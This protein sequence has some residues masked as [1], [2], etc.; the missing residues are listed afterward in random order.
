MK[1]CF[2]HINIYVFKVSLFLVLFF[3][4]KVISQNFTLIGDKA[5][6]TLGGEQ[7]PIILK[8]NNNLIIAGTTSFTGINGD[9]TEVSC[10]T[11]PFETDVWILMIDVNS[12][13]LW[14]KTIGGLNT[15]KLYG[16]ELGS[17]KNIVFT[18]VTNSDSSCDI[19]TL[20]RGSS[21]FWLCS[22]DSNGNKI[23]DNRYGS[24]SAEFGGRLL[25]CENKDYLLL[26]ASSGGI[27][28]DKTTV[29]LGGRDFWLVRTDSLGNKLWDKTLGGSGDETFATQ[30]DCS[31]LSIGNNEYLI[32]GRTN[33]FQSGTISTNGFG[34]LDLWFAKVDSVGS[35]VWDKRF[36]GNLG[37]NVT[38][39]IEVNDGYLL[40]GASNSKLGGTILDTGIIGY[41]VWLVKID[42]I[43]NQLWEK[44]YGGV[45]NDLG[46]DIQSAPDGGYWVL[47]QT[48]SQIGYDITE[49]SY[50]GNDYW[51]FKIDSVGNKSWDKRFGGPGNDFASSFIIM[52]DS[53]IFICGHAEAG[54]SAVK[55]DSGKGSED[56]WIVHFNYYN[57][58]TGI[59]ST[60]TVNGITVSPNPTQNILNVKGL[61]MGEYEAIL[62]GIDGRVIKQ[63]LLQGGDEVRYSLDDAS[64]GM[65]LLRFNG[66][67]FTA[68]I[69]VMKE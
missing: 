45:S 34:Q 41:D 24:N 10:A 2:I 31:F 22:L 55:T 38:K 53:S 42:T 46:I 65:Y 50:G 8:Y 17:D 40:L 23:F 15:D 36:G 5:F 52:Q 59:N 11:I 68:T 44:R 33:S 3:P 19:S 49:N 58:T 14:N 37:D 18:G 35:V 6:G 62:F 26:G 64:P 1:K 61:P 29:G 66:D 4:I 67:K 27:S 12:N 63:S 30:W 39:I 47:A 9:K 48:N 25:S 32:G 16:L 13:I 56:Y 51:I 21:D 28:G 20:T 60:S 69:K 54:I 57:N 43:G 7:D